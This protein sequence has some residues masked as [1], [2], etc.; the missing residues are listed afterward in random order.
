MTADSWGPWQ[1]PRVFYFTCTS[2][3]PYLLCDQSA[4]QCLLQEN[5]KRSVIWGK[6]II[7]YIAPSRKQLVAAIRSTTCGVIADAPLEQ[8]GSA[9]IALLC[10]PCAQAAPCSHLA[11]PQAGSAHRS[12]VGFKLC[13]PGL[14]GGLEL[15]PGHVRCGWFLTS[16]HNWGSAF[17]HS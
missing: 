3:S 7:K 8:P 11:A 2:F 16:W 10:C 1:I 5:K 14:Q 17:Q 12:P 9:A 15:S 13:W 4:S 6:H